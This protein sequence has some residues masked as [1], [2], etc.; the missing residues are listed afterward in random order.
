MVEI[1]VWRLADD[2]VAVPDTHARVLDGSSEVTGGRHVVGFVEDECV[3]NVEGIDAKCDGDCGDDEDD[4]PVCRSFHVVTI[5][6][7]SN[8]RAQMTNL[9]RRRM[10][11]CR[12]STRGLTPLHAETTVIRFVFFTRF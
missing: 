8:A 2:G 7:Q 11:C 5:F 6:C 10:K 1:D 12:G 4:V 9:I 3:G